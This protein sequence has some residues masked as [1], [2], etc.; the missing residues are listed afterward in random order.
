VVS[1]AP[2]ALGKAIVTVGHEKL[3]DAESAARFKAA[4]R[5]WLGALKGVLERD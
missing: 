4:W 2:K 3:P 5:G 1:V